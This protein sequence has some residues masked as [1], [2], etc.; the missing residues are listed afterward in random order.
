M[1]AYDEKLLSR[2]KEFVFDYQKKNGI[3][4]SYRK[5][6]HGLNISPIHKVQRYLKVLT[7]RGDIKKNKLGAIEMPL[8]LKAEKIVYV[9]VVGAV[10]C[11][12][13]KLAIEN[14]ERQIP[15]PASLIGGDDK[16]TYILEAEGYS[17]IDA[18]IEPGDLLI[19]K[20]D[21]DYANGDMVIASI[22]NEATAKRY[23]NEGDKIILQPKNQ[24]MDDIIIDDLSQFEIKGRVIH[25]LKSIKRFEKRSIKRFEKR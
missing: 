17:M 1:K 2:M 13:Q 22:D 7:D 25:V 16:D 5:I 3:S 10:A 18:G 24:E 8:N 6:M 9:P 12:Q 4:P 20:K 14:I 19:V 11:G 21:G 15:L 23:Y